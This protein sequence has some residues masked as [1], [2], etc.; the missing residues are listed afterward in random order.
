MSFRTRLVAVAAAAVGISVALA[1]AACYVSV[2]GTLFKDVDT[3]LSH[4]AGLVVDNQP[5]PPPD[6]G[7][8]RRPGGS[9]CSAAGSAWS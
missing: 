1:S 2:R 5:L 6:P 3:E 9:P 8:G 4:Q 7:P